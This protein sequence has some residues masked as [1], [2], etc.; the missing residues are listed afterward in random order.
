M[1]EAR[2]LAVA[3]GATGVLL[4]ALASSGQ[5]KLGLAGP[6]DSLRLTLLRIPEIQKELKLSADQRDKIARIAEQTKE[7]KK[8]V[9]TDHGKSKEKGK[10]KAVDPAAKEQ[11]SLAREAL[12]AELEDMERQTDRRVNAVL[13]SSQRTRMTQIVLRVEGPSAFLRPDLIDALNLGPAQVEAIREILNGMNTAADQYKDAQKRAFDLAKSSGESDLEKIGKEQQKGQTRAYAYK[14]SK[15]VM[16]EIIRQLDRR[17]RDRYTKLLGPPFDP[18][19]L[20]GKEGRPLLDGSS[21]LRTS[22]IRQPAVQAELKLTDQQK[23]KLAAAAPVAKV[24]D[25]QQRARLDQIELQ[26]AGPAALTRPEVARALRL[27]DEQ[28]GQIQAVLDE[29]L[30]SHQQLR[31]SIKRAATIEGEGDI[32][33]QEER[34]EQEKARLRTGSAELR[35]QSMQ[36]INAM[37]TRKQREAFTKLLG[38]PFDFAKL[39][40]QPPGP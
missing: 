18:T 2:L 14:L 4:T 34:K 12:N 25:S 32:G 23:G 10:P 39:R 13:D 9:E 15:Q 26:G 38:D 5:E 28:V 20:T 22:L 16:P 36:R 6:G 3:L 31:E 1:R 19:T 29:L 33:R 27:G 30:G 24:L 40:T 21:D 35:G 7:A 37:L 11:E 8:Q 17:Q